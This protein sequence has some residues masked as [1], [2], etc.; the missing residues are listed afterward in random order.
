MQKYVQN[1]SSNGG[2]NTA[3]EGALDVGLIVRFE[4]AP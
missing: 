3:L 2:P 4:W 1:S